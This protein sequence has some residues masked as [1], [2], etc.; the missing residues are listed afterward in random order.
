MG[1]L[2]HTITLPGLWRVLIILL[3]FTLYLLSHHLL[4]MAENLLHGIA[5]RLSTH[6]T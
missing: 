6:L 3:R 5:L 4:L 1:D 2:I